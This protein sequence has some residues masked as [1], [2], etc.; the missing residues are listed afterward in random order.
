MSVANTEQEQE[1]LGFAEP[2]AGEMPSL[3]CVG[4]VTAIADGKVTEVKRD[5]DGD[6]KPNYQ[7]NIISISGLGAGRSTKVNLL[8]R[9]EWLRP[10]FDLNEQ[11][12]VLKPSQ[13]KA[14]RFVYENNLRAPEGSKI[15]PVLQGLAGNRENYAVL[16]NRLLR[17]DEITLENVTDV[18]RT[19]LIDE[20]YGEEIGYVL[21]QKEE[22]TGEKDENGRPERRKT[23]Y[24]EVSKFFEVTEKNLESWRKSCE[25]PGSKYRM[26][27]GGEAF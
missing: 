22:L 9:P 17:L 5:A 20:G 1:L 11:L 10:G 8:Y 18:L 24:Y 16:A 19:F 6:E 13:A 26:T 4:S 25:K 2:P 7:M 27:Y 12:E 21:K 3:V 23:A 14:I 15:V